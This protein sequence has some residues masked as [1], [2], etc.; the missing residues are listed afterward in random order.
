M[1]QIDINRIHLSINYR[2][3][4]QSQYKISRI[5]TAINYLGILPAE[6]FATP[7]VPFDELTSLRSKIK[8]RA[9]CTI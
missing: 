6:N 7:R 4:L 9:R 2:K 1:I 3:K 8:W 5:T